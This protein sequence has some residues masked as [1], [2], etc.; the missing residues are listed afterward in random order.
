MKTKAEALQAASYG[1]IGH[2]MAVA[3]DIIHRTA[4]AC[5]LP[6]YCLADDRR[7]GLS[8]S[9]SSDGAEVGFA[10]AYDLAARITGDT[11]AV[12]YGEDRPPAL[13]DL[14]GV[15][16]AYKRASQNK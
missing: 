14:F 9:I 1:R 12:P 16:D 2:E 10:S 3:T 4:R 11:R 5:F 6:R 13:P 7:D 8:G 15:G